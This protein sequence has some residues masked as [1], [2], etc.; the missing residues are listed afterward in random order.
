ML[1][2][3]STARKLYLLTFITATSLIGL[4]FYAVGDLRK[5]N[6][7]TRTLY[8]DR[9]LCIQQLSNIRRVYSRDIRTIPQNIKR[10]KLSFTDAIKRIRQAQEIID[11]NWHNYKRTNFTPEEKLLAKQTDILKNQADEANRNLIAILSKEDTLA[12]NRLV[13]EENPAESTPFAIKVTQLMDLQVKIAKEILNNSKTLYQITSANFILFIVLSL[14]IALSLSFYIIK[15]VRGLIKDLLRSNDEIKE[16]ERKYRSLLENASDAI[17][18]SNFEGHFID[19]NESMC[20][21]MGYSKE[22]LLQ[23]NIEDIIDPEELK[24]DPVIQGYDLPDHAILRERRLVRKDRVKFDVESN[25]KRLAENQ[26]L[27]ITRDITERK[28]AEE[29]LKKSEEKYR[30]LIETACDAIYLLDLEGNFTDA[31]EIMCLMTGYTKEELLRLNVS[32]IVDPEQLKTDPL[33]QGYSHLGKSVIRERRFVRKDGEIFEVEINVNK[34]ADNQVLV[35]ARDISD[36]KQMEAELREAELKFRIL[37]EKSMVGIYIVQNGKFIYVNPRFAEVFGYP[38]SELINTIDV[39]AIIHDDYRH[40]ANEY[41]RRRV[42]GESESV[43]YEAMG[44]KKDGTANWVEFYG[45]TTLIGTAPTI[46]GSMIEITERKR[47][48]ELIL[49]E[50]ILSETIINS[51]PGIFYLQSATGQYLLW[52]KNFETVTGY[53][54]KEIEK[55]ETADLIVEE[56]LQKVMDT[57]EKLFTEGYGMVEATAK[58]KDGTRVPFLLTGIPIMYEDQ[59]CLLGTGIDISSRVKAEEELRSSEQKYKFLFESSPLPLWMIAKDDFSFIAVN[60]ATANLYGYTSDEFLQSNVS[61]IRPKEDIGQQQELLREELK[62]PTDRGI[63]RHVKKDGTIIFVNV[64]VNDIMFEG[65]RVRLGLTTD[66]TEKLKAEESLKKSEAN[67]KTIMDATDT[68]YALLD[69]D[70]N[71]ISFNQT[72]VKFVNN[73]FQH[74]PVKGDKLADYF[75]K[76]R[77][78][79]FLNYTH[80]VLQGKNI[81]YE[82]NYPQPDGSVLWYYIRLFPITNDQGAIFGLMLA[83]SN[84]TD[85]KTSEIHLEQLNENLQKHAK[86]LA[87]SNAELEQFAFVASHDLQE[88]LRMVTSFMT[89][90]EK[91]YGSVID[92]KGRQY[93]NFA[94]DG[95]KRMRQIILDLLDFSRVGNTEDDMEEVS[96]NKLLNEILA[97]Y[98]R[99]IEELKANIT[100]EDLPTLQTFKAPARQVFQNLV[101]NSLK[102]HK[103][104]RPPVIQISCK[105]TKT[106]FQFSVKD[107]GIGISPKYFDKIFIIFQRLHNKDEYSGTGMGLAITKKIVETLGGKI[108]VES[109]EGKGS[110]F[111]FTLPKK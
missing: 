81:S 110:T 27:V 47:A 36:R 14:V 11:T 29:Q 6:D 1:N 68:A 39:T 44:K 79:Q 10:H 19:A 54:G 18:I 16:S 98:R 48:E 21:L 15:N 56:D 99:Q 111:Y 104:G 31:N 87:I 62:G 41:V 89:Q 52:N 40:I 70:L 8:S 108:W 51:L 12:I 13:Q 17:Y 55:L 93:I 73:Q 107:N 38:P 35:I 4:G 100:I 84:I 88:P 20:K 28:I 90:L 72:A 23:L 30:R 92:D 45:S 85:H 64:I 66:V 61:I 32:V 46:I 82:I 74:T 94:V 58:T 101:G 63:V 102:Y 57:I 75:P 26:V 76:E 3:L 77:F 5:M 53:T 34:F 43:H 49:K 2:K 42:S 86:E 33:I 71:V 7:N 37:A 109:E 50:K 67:L 25:I 80:Q 103:A 106:H 78:S 22:E 96:F 91:K 60:D 105:E 59:L 65:R 95:A 97:L 24:T 69:K 9:V 83:L